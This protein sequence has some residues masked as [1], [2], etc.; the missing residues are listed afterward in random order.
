MWHHVLSYQN[1]NRSQNGDVTVHV[2]LRCSWA[3]PQIVMRQGRTCCR[4]H[5][6]SIAMQ[7]V[8]S[9]DHG[10]MPQWMSV[11]QGF[12]GCGS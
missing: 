6:G 8:Q 11:K 1:G 7:E 5:K 2:S 3:S 9:K 10:G 12:A 4:S